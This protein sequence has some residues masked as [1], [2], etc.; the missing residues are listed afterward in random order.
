MKHQQEN[1]SV[2]EKEAEGG[3]R[4]KDK[5][6]YQVRGARE[7]VFVASLGVTS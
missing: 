6:I 3:T 1:M 7:D 5:I 2:R 4:R